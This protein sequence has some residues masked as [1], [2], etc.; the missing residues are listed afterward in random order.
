MV[1]LEGL[2]MEKTGV[3]IGEHPAFMGVAQRQTGGCWGEAWRGRRR[4]RH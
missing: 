3:R 2:E 4:V 1:T